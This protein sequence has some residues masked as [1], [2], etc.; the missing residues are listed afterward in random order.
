MKNQVLNDEK[1]LRSRSLHKL[2]DL[3]DLNFYKSN[4]GKIKKV[5]FETIV[6][7]EYIVGFSDNYIR[8]KVK[9]D[10]KMIKKI[11]NVKLLFIENDKV[12]GE[13]Y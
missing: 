7:D 6:E 12:I 1:I 9:G 3:K 8:V 11:F 2:S 5:L 13:I 10:K 4:I